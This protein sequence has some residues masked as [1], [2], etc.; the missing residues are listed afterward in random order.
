MGNAVQK[1][2]SQADTQ[3]KNLHLP[4][5]FLYL[6]FPLP[7]VLFKL[8]FTDTYSLLAVH[9][10]DMYIRHDNASHYNYIV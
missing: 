3:I 9:V 8:V 4:F 1:Q 6:T 5:S 10:H 2:R 7:P